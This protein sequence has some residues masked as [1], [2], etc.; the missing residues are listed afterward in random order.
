MIIF[1]CYYVIIN[2]G[3]CL[4]LQYEDYHP[5]EITHQVLILITVKDPN[6]NYDNFFGGWDN[7]T[8]D[9]TL[10]F[11]GPHYQT[12]YDSDSSTYYQEVEVAY[13][14]NAIWPTSEYEFTLYYQFVP[15]IPTE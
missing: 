1:G 3:G 5:T 9:F 10:A 11:E 13:S 15:V 7:L 2:S 4:N 6:P 8:I 14:W 12:D